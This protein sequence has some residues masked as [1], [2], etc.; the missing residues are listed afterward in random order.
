MLSGI[1]AFVLFAACN[2]IKRQRTP[3]ASALVIVTSL[4]GRRA[5]DNSGRADAGTAAGDVA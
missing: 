3:R 5:R 4:P 1:P 2:N